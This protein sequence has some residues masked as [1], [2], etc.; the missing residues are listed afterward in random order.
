MSTGVRERDDGAD[1]PFELFDPLGPF[2]DRA[3][4]RFV[5]LDV[6]AGTV[7]IV[8][9]QG[10]LEQ[11]VPPE[12]RAPRWASIG[13]PK[14]SVVTTWRDP[15][16]PLPP[17]PT[18]RGTLPV[19]ELGHGARAFKIGGAIADVGLRVGNGL[20]VDRRGDLFQ[21]ELD[22]H[23]RLQITDV[24]LELFSEIA[25]NRCDRLLLRVFRNGNGHRIKMDWN[26]DS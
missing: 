4:G 5:R 24:L 21:N 16:A 6:D 18:K 11:A 7:D 9:I 14:R 1:V 19:C 26:L 22:E 15:N 25:L 3:V 12:Y 23:R 10:I 17:R 20:V 13:I 8:T 2:V